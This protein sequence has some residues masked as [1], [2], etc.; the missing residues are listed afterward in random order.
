MSLKKQKASLSKETKK[1][2][3]QFSMRKPKSIHS[4][5][6]RFFGR[7]IVE[8]YY[9][10]D[11]KPDGYCDANLFYS[12]EEEDVVEHYKYVLETVKQAIACAT[13]Y[14][15]AGYPDLEEEFQK[16]VHERTACPPASELMF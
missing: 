10:T 2:L 6:Y 8:C 11:N 12:D 4:W 13:A 15:V 1:N 7:D 14:K 16:P 5:N 3:E 9:N